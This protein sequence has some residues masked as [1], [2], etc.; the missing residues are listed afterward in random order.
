MEIKMNGIAVQYTI[1][2]RKNNQDLFNILSDPDHQIYMVDN[3]EDYDDLILFLSAK[4]K[5]ITTMFYS[6]FDSEF[7]K[8]NKKLFF[9]IGNLFTDVL[10]GICTN[11]VIVGKNDFISTL[12]ENHT[13][14]E[15]N[16]SKAGKKMIVYFSPES[17]IGEVYDITIL[18]K[19]QA[20]QKE[21]DALNFSKHEK[22]FYDIIKGTLVVINPYS[23]SIK[24]LELTE[25]PQLREY[26]SLFPRITKAW[27]KSSI[28]DAR[29]FIKVTQNKEASVEDCNIHVDQ[30]ILYVCFVKET[31]LFNTMADVSRHIYNNPREDI[32]EKLKKMLNTEDF[33][34]FSNSSSTDFIIYKEESKFKIK[35]IADLHLRENCSDIISAFSKENILNMFDIGIDYISNIKSAN[36][37]TKKPNVYC[38]TEKYYIWGDY[39]TKNLMIASKEK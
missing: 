22:I 4:K 29:D 36:K 7:R 15:I 13:F 28:C 6:D 5:A 39:F 19:K 12:Q 27:N 21:L 20:L 10:D 33:I 2:Q 34:Y 26:V 37:K 25:Y 35:S 1:E 18:K 11:C 17:E 16:I 24:K 9:K 14:S 30:G 3:G 23:G 31:H 38:E 32:M 8:L